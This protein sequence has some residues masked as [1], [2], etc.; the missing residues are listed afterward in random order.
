MHQQTI[1]QRC[2]KL[3]SYIIVELDDGSWYLEHSS[4]LTAVLYVCLMDW[5]YELQESSSCMIK[6]HQ[7]H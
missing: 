6:L 4:K 2:S 7:N 3:K 1:T 5:F